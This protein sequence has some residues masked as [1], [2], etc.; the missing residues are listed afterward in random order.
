[1][2]RIKQLFSN[3]HYA[4]KSLGLGVIVLSALL[5]SAALAAE[6]PKKGDVARGARAWGENCVRCHNARDPKEMTDAQ[7]KTTV[8]HMRVRA[9]LTGQQVRDILEFLQK[10]N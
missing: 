10:S 3:M 7:W 1:M 2:N 4:S 5:S 8:Y 6:P 9:G